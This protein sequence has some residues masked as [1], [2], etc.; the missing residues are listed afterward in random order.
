MVLCIVTS[1]G[2]LLILVL[3]TH[4]K[5]GSNYVVFLTDQIP[6]VINNLLQVSLELIIFEKSPALCSLW[7][8]GKLQKLFILVCII[9]MIDCEHLII[10]LFT[11]L[12]IWFH[13]HHWHFFPDPS[14]SSIAFIYFFFT[15]LFFWNITQDILSKK[16][17]NHFYI[18][19][20]HEIFIPFIYLFIISCLFVD[21]HAIESD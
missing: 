11:M 15:L 19:Q 10:S 13:H 3:L 21:I 16:G 8:H 2:V 7:K 20:N 14:S 1:I 12:E 9:F 18:K 17:K 6:R 4:T 5:F